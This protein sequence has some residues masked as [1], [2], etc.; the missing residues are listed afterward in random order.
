MALACF[1]LSF[2]FL[3]KKYFTMK[4]FKIRIEYTYFFDGRDWFLSFDF[5]SKYGFKI[6]VWSGVTPRSGSSC[7][8]AAPGSRH[9]RTKTTRTPTWATLSRTDILTGTWATS[10]TTTMTRRSM[11]RDKLLITVERINLLVVVSKEVF[12]EWSFLAISPIFPERT[13]MLPKKS[14]NFLLVSYLWSSF[15]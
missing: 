6:A 10:A 5:R 11:S 9:C 14:E 3:D 4:E 7:R 12:D 1:Q 2:Y 13:L 8:R 15:H